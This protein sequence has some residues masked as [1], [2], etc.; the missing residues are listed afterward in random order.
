MPLEASRAGSWRRQPARLEGRG[1][2]GGSWMRQ[3]VR[4]W[5]AWRRRQRGSGG[6]GEEAAA[7]RWSTGSRPQRGSEG[8]RGGSHL[9]MLM[10]KLCKRRVRKAANCH[11]VAEARRSEAAARI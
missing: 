6:E 10:L 9:I 11:F 8:R 3:L 2:G 7:W 5:M 4:F 1:A